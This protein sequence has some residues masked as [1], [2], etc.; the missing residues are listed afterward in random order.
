MDEEHF[1][2]AIS[3]SPDDNLVRLV[4]ADWLDE[5]NDPPRRVRSVASGVAAIATRRSTPPAVEKS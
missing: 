1:L 5:Q 2:Q 4:Y 3:A